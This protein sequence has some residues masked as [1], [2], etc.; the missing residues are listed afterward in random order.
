MLSI[1]R[2]KV[3]GAVQGFPVHVA[4]LLPR[5][6]SVEIGRCLDIPVH[7]LRHQSGS[8][9]VRFKLQVPMP[10]GVTVRTHFNQLHH[11]RR[12]LRP[13]DHGRPRFK[14]HL[15]RI[16][17]GLS[18]ERSPSTPL[19]QHE[20]SVAHVQPKERLWIT[21]LAVPQSTHTQQGLRVDRVISH[22]SQFIVQGE[23]RHTQMHAIPG[24]GQLDS[25]PLVADSPARS[26]HAGLIVAFNGEVREARTTAFPYPEGA[27]TLDKQTL[28]RRE[29]ARPFAL[30]ADHE[31]NRP[32]GR[33]R[34]DL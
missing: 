18:K 20:R 6:R 31:A 7:R 8:Q 34:A 2:R 19:L 16:S 22:Q 12:P 21:P 10:Y 11:T 29:F 24:P 1:R 25:K 17:K 23:Q 26:Q 4:K 33:P 32:F 28:R 27:V 15:I 30:A 5:H 9:P 14:S 13:H 3:F